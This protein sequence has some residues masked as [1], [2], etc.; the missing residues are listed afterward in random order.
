[1][2]GKRTRKRWLKSSV[3]DERLTAI[4][5]TASL[6]GWIVAND[7]L[8]QTTSI[9]RALGSRLGSETVQFKQACREFPHSLRGAEGI[10]H[11]SRPRVRLISDGHCKSGVPIP[12]NADSCDSLRLVSS[13]SV[14]AARHNQVCAARR[15]FSLDS[16]RPIRRRPY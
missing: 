2:S 11:S 13:A 15:P 10:P 9:G 16:D 14:E 4:G 1:M 3:F 5:I 12:C 8:S 7:A 6:G